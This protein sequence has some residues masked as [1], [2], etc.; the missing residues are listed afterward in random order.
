MSGRHQPQVTAS[1]IMLLFP[2]EGSQ[3]TRLSSSAGLGVN[4]LWTCQSP[5]YRICSLN[6]VRASKAN[7]IKKGKNAAITTNIKISYS[8]YRK[9][10]QYKEKT[11]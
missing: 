4:Y 7:Y 9:M 11:T 2:A 8:N 6:S 3:N 5:A 10:S 1:S